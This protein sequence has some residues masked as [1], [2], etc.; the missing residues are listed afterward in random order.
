[1]SE[2]LVKDTLGYIYYYYCNK[3]ILIISNIF[4][5]QLLSTALYIF[6]MPC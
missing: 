2:T 1:M 3:E 6:I 5:L 4:K